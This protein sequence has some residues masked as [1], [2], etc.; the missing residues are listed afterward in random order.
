MAAKIF[1]WVAHPSP[2]SLNAT[3]ADAYQQA[4]RS[5]GA[6]IRRMDLSDM[7]FSTDSFTGFDGH[8][9]LEPDL[10]KWQQ[11]ILWADHLLFVHPY[12]WGAMPGRAKAVL[13]RA[14]LPGF[15]FKYRE[16]GATWD[17]LLAGRTGDII[18]TSDT[19]PWFDTL[20]YR[21]PGRRVMRNQVFGFCGIKTRKV[22]QFGVVRRSG[23]AQRQKWIAN[24]ASMGRSAAV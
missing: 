22:K 11:N 21:R 5:Q 7:R 19:P 14:L 24:A 18:I 8:D 20:V 13:D 23:E 9:E 17:R 12:W 10:A 16:G 6:E 1:I 3:L 4:A 15:A 2:N